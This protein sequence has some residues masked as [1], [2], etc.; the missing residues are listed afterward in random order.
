MAQVFPG[1][2]RA[3]LI[4]AADGSAI[5]GGSGD[6]SQ[7]VMD[8]SSL[9]TDTTATGEAAVNPALTPFGNPEGAT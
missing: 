5:A 3:L 4:M 1:S 2:E 7:P 9:M 8:V 6:C